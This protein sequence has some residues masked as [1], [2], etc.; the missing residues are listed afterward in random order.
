MQTVK[1]SPIGR[2]VDYQIIDFVGCLKWLVMP[3]ARSGEG[4]ELG[5]LRCCKSLAPVLALS[6]K[7]QEAWESCWRVAAASKMLCSRSFW[8]LSG[9]HFSVAEAAAVAAEDGVAASAALAVCRV[10]I[11]LVVRMFEI[12]DQ[13]SILVAY[14]NWRP[15]TIVHY[16]A[17]RAL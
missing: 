16:S 11:G 13:I 9:T 10:Y 4:A 12:A 5:I 6:R 1:T 3:Q 7:G 14:I 2:A 17:S 15:W 8:R